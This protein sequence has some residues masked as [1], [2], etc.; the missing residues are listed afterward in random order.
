MSTK[1]EEKSKSKEMGWDRARGEKRLRWRLWEHMEYVYSNIVWP[2]CYH[3]TS[4]GGSECLSGQFSSLLGTGEVRPCMLLFHYLNRNP[5]FL[6]VCP[7]SLLSNSLL[8]TLHSV[9]GPPHSSKARLGSS[10]V[11]ANINKVPFSSKGRNKQKWA[12][13]LFKVHSVR[14]LLWQMRTQK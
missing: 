7:T 3:G 12:A 6:Q 2:W 9:L 1:K 5:L 8:Y 13:G 4:F 10:L 11:Q 14:D